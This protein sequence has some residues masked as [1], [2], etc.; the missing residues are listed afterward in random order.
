MHS[1][2]SDRW[3]FGTVACKLMHFLVNVSAYVT[4]YTLVLVTVVRY[5]TV[6]HNAK[7]SRFRTRPI[8]TCLIGA[9]WVVACI[10]N[11]F[12]FVAYGTFSEDRTPDVISCDLYDGN[13]GKPMYALFFLLAYLLPLVIIALLSLGIRRQMVKNRPTT[14]AA[15]LRKMRSARRKKQIGRLLI[16]VVILFAVS[17][18]PIH[19]H[20]LVAYFG[21]ISTSDIYRLLTFFWYCLAYAN[22]C[23]N[24]IVYNCASKDFRIAFKES[25]VC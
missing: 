23:V 13:N 9:I 12:I 24:P 21:E 4:V 14:H 3:H 5:L 8:T 25:V 22:S 20:L 19:I 15:A 2:A 6:V 11:S 16:S 7:T 17:W 18:L 10:A 1:L